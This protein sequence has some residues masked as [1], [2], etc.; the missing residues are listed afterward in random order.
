MRNPKKNFRTKLILWAEVI[1]TNACKPRPLCL[2]CGFIIHALK[3]PLIGCG[4]NRNREIVI[5]LDR[6]VSC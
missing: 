6:I 2:S 4:I 1:H 5:D 3:T